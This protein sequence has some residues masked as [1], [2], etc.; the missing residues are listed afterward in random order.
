MFY[1]KKCYHP[2]PNPLLS[3]LQ[4]ATF[5]DVVIT[6]SLPADSSLLPPQLLN[7][8]IARAPLAVLKLDA[9]T[10]RPDSACGRA[11]QGSQ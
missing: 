6:L 2:S 8:K 11:Q 9:L 5:T 7:M 1:F 10:H 4:L 3:S